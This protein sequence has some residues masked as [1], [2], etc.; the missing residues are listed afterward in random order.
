M[1]SIKKTRPRLR[2]PDGV[3][4]AS[5]GDAVVVAPGRSV[6]VFILEYF[7]ASHQSICVLMTVL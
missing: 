7:L 2:A 6:R 4:L 5:D 3:G 1:N